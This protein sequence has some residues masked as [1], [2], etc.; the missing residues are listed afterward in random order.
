[1]LTQIR[2][3]NLMIDTQISYDYLTL[4]AHLHL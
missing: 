1:M 3:Y 4:G 2:H